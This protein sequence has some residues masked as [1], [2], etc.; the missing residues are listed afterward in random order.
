MKRAIARLHIRALPHTWSSRRGE[1]WVARLY[2]LV[3][4]VGYV[5]TVEREGKVVGVMSGVGR[6]ILT[7]VVDPGWQRRGIG[8]E[9]ISKIKG[10]CY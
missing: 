9:L 1:G 6:V 10:K 8:S 5:Q 4:R 2:E 3:E 7:L